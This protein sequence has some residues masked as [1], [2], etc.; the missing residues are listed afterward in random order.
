[1]NEEDIESLKSYYEKAKE[2]IK[3]Q[4][5][6]IERLK[7]ICKKMHLWIFLN[8]GDEQKIYDEIGLTKEENEMLGYSGQLKIKGDKE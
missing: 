2:V 6:E 5:N 4:H 1:M 3:D 8:S 7:T